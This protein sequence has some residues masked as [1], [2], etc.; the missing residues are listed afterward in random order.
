[1]KTPFLL[2]FLKSQLGIFFILIFFF[3]QQFG[4]K[5]GVS[6][7]LCANLEAIINRMGSLEQLS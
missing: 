3:G 7:Q 2:F 6:K 4:S 1:L 5:S